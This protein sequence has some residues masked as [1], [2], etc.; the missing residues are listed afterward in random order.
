M[1]QV[2]R[3]SRFN[4]ETDNRSPLRNAYVPTT[5]KTGVHLFFKTS[6]GDPLIAA[7]A[8]Q[9]KVVVFT[10]FGAIIKQHLHQLMRSVYGN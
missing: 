1:I 5:A 10:G 8:A 3:F 4:K 6:Q 9:S 7:N 2:S